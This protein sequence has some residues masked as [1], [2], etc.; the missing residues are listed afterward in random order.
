MAAGGAI[1][2]ATSAAPD[3]KIANSAAITSMPAR[4]PQEAANTSH[5]VR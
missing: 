2:L 3:G 4:N 1:R 5:D